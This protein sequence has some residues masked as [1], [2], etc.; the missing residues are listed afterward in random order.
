MAK[1]PRV[2]RSRRNRSLLRQ[3][4]ENEL[5]EKRGPVKL[6]ILA[7]CMA[8]LVAAT[9]GASGGAA[10]RLEVKI[11]TPPTGQKYFIYE[12]QKPALAG[13]DVARIA[14]ANGLTRVKPLQGRETQAANQRADVYTGH[15][16]KA[17]MVYVPSAGSLRWIPDLAAQRETRRALRNR[18][19]V[20]RSG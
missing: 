20:P 1:K 15:S 5:G 3:F 16:R 4:A 6:G 2:T 13:G 7:V 11:P 9:G 12:M 8:L 17:L 14:G 10:D 19:R 18:V